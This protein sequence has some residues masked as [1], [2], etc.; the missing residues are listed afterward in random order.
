MAILKIARMGHPI[1]RRAAAAI[2]DPTAPEIARLAAD[3]IETMVDAPGIG[4]AAPQVH[5]AKRLVVFQVPGARAGTP[6][7]ESGE[8]G[9][10]PLTV[11][12]NPQIEALTT[13]MESGWE[14]CLSLPG[15]TGCVP[16]FRRIRY[17][18]WGLTGEAIERVAE[19]FHA[20]VVQHEC[21]HLDGILYPMRITDLSLFGFVEDIRRHW[22]QA[23]EPPAD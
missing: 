2:D 18:G 20:R 1:L 16:R 12:I 7:S 5:V 14:G 21:D 23:A 4:L 3:M 19:G 15:L 22:P 8:E 10:V 17:R 11:L 9:P 13:E 6:D